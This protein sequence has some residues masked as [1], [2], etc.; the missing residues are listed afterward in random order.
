MAVFESEINHFFSIV[1]ITSTDS[2]ETW[3][4]RRIIDIPTDL[5]SSA[6]APQINNLDGTLVVSFQMNEDLDPSAPSSSY[7]TNSVVKLLT[8]EQDD[9]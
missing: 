7:P 5:Y 3:G 2:D 4:N 9:S 6:G 1:S 8:S